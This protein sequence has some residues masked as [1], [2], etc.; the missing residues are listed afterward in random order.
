MEVATLP[1]GRRPP[2]ESKLREP[3]RLREAGRLRPRQRVRA[4]QRVE[5]AQ[6]AASIALSAVSSYLEAEMELPAFFGHLSETVA[7]LVGARRVAFWRLSPLGA[8]AV[9]REPFGFRPQSPVRSLR[10]PVDRDGR[11]LRRHSVHGHW[12]G[13]RGDRFP[14]PRRTP[15]HRSCSTRSHRPSDRSQQVAVRIQ[16]FLGCGRPTTGRSLH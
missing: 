5:K 6:T 13:A 7:G 8:L 15:G 1:A 3:G 14:D 9:Q 4:V 12:R 16:T 2:G 11:R 10:I